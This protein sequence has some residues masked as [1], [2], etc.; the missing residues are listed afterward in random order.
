VQHLAAAT[1]KGFAELDREGVAG[2]VVE[3]QAH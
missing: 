2:V 1:G 3:Q